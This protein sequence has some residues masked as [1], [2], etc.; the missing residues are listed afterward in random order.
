MGLGNLFLFFYC[1]DY[2][3]I[4]PIG[5]RRIGGGCGEIWLC[6]GFFECSVSCGIG[7]CLV[8][9]L[10]LLGV[11]NKLSLE[12]VGGRESVVGFENFICGCECSRCLKFGWAFGGNNVWEVVLIAARLLLSCG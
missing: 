11:L 1:S 12:F 7:L 5:T 4:L 6:C 3:R 9:M 8:L 2:H 10:D